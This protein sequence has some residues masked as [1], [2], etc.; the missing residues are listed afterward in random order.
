MEWYTMV[1]KRYAEFN[2]RS[3]RKEY[4]MFAL[5]NC[6]ICL[7]PYIA[8]IILL[9][10]GN[11]IGMVLMGLVCV[12]SLTVLVPGLAVAVRRL[13][14]T[15]KSGW[16]ILLGVIP[17]VGGIILLVFLVSDS[18]PGDNLYGPNPKMI[19]TSTAII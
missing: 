11:K 15:G 12:Y 14:D 16:L 13:H 9:A 10:T 19:A 8:G 7:V 5:F 18:N 1:L 6:L 3:R 17:V 4:W 2:G